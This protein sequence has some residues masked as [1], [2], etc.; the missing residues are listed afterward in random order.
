MRILLIYRG[1]PADAP[2]LGQELI[3]RET[4]HA[5]Q[6]GYILLLRELQ[7]LGHGVAVYSPD[8]GVG[9]EFPIV[10]ATKGFDVALIWKRRGLSTASNEYIDISCCPIRAIW[11]DNVSLSLPEHLNLTHFLWATQEI[12]QENIWKFPN[13]V[14]AVI[15]HASNITAR[16]DPKQIL[17][18]GLF[19]GR[20]MGWYIDSLQ[21]V[22]K[23]REMVAYALKIEKPSGGF[24]NFRPGK[25]IPEE[26]NEASRLLGKNIIIRPACNAQREAQ[27]LSSYSWGLVTAANQKPR[28]VTSSSKI[29][30]YWHLGLPVFCDERVPEIRHLFSSPIWAGEG[31][32]YQSPTSITVGIE[33]LNYIL[34]NDGYPSRC[35]IRDWA[36]ANHTYRQRAKEF[37]NAFYAKATY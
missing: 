27:L 36:E 31:F 13:R 32:D 8:T 2:P 9:R 16:V 10:T 22:A 33:R 24:W 3:D 28:Q 6:T 14:H 4:T 35:A 5:S 11:Y 23:E 37:E 15:E 29:W 12:E 25:Y 7:K 19:L 21:A 34:R 20:L 18:E 30:D 17:H 1:L 26:L